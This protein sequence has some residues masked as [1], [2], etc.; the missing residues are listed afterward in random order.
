MSPNQAIA[1]ATMIGVVTITV[2]DAPRWEVE[3]YVGLL[4]A[5]SGVAVV[6]RASPDLGKGLAGLIAA[7]MILQR[8]ERVV[9]AVTG[10]LR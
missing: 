7:V 9:N 5:M 1:W 4:A 8:G 3:P 10:R 2:A 6:S